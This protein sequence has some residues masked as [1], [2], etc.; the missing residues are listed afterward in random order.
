MKRKKR[1]YWIRFI[2]A[3]FS[4]VLIAVPIY[5]MIIG[6]MMELAEIHRRPRI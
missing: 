6:G 4:V 5:F 1:I 2:I 3:T